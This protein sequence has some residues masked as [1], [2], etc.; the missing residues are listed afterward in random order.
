MKHRCA[1]LGLVLFPGR[2]DKEKLISIIII[3]TI[4]FSQCFLVS[5]AHKKRWKFHQRMTLWSGPKKPHRKLKEQ[6]NLKTLQKLQRPNIRGA[7][8]FI[9]MITEYQFALMSLGA[10]KG[11]QFN[12]CT[13]FFSIF[14]TTVGSSSSVTIP[15]SHKDSLRFESCPTQVLS[16]KVLSTKV[17]YDQQEPSDSITHWVTDLLLVKRRGLFCEWCLCKEWVS[18][19]SSVRWDWDLLFAEEI[20]CAF[21]L[22]GFSLVLCFLLAWIKKSQ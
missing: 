3:Y 13:I 17:R 18:H 21:W 10:L 2:L 12:T 20:M 22:S 5:S 8:Q 19:W 14:L 9:T 4:Y 15:Q 1:H 11:Q 16:Y 6:F 7:H